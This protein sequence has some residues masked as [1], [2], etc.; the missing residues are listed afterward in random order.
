MRVFIA[1]W[2]V[3]GILLLLGQAVWRLTPLALEPLSPNILTPTQA[4]IYIIWAAANAFLEG[5]RGFQRGFCPRVVTRAIA[6]SKNPTPLRVLLAPP[7]CMGL[8]SAP[9][10]RMIVSWSVTVGIVMLI[11][12]V[13]H[14]SQPWRGI[15]DGGVV[16]GLAWGMAALLWEFF[17]VQSPFGP[18]PGRGDGS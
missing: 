6:L 8:F 7:Y 1:V 5:Y 14:S 2:G 9:R 15:I 16:I 10:R 17:Y 13:R 4:F 18:Q 12:I 11:V 3:G